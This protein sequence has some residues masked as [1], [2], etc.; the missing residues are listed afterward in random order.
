QHS[1]EADAERTSKMMASFRPIE[2]LACETTPRR[3]DRADIDSETGKP[4]VPIVGHDELIVRAR[5]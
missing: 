4:S 3:L 1:E 2:A 5:D